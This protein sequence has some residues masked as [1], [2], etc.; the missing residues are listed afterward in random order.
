[1]IMDKI[2][3]ELGFSKN[4]AKI[5]LT[6]LETGPNTVGKIAENSGVHRTNVYDAL[7]R[8][9]EKGLITYIL[10]ENIKYF[11]ATNPIKLMNILKQKEQNLKSILP[12]FLANY[13]LT[14]KSKVHIY[15]GI[16]AVKAILNDFLKVKKP[17][18]VY[19]IPKEALKLMESFIIHYHKRRVAKKIVMKHIYNED[20]Q[21]RIK[22][23]NKL[24]YT[25]AK[26]LPEKYNSPV[27]TNICGNQIV[28]ILWSKIPLVIQIESE[29]V[30]NSYKNY[31]GL[32]WEIAKK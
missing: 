2:L 7:N 17:I 26:Y 24:K 15:E 25:E 11:E 32:I 12:R 20:A 3:R 27:S 16:F 9:I 13:K 28:L 19:G 4:E 31:F 21:K 6:L 22:H 18:L 10:R 30:S 5:Y 1:M 23:L 8:L 14:K 29:E